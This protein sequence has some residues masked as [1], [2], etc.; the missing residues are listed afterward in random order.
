MN[1]TERNLR[2][3]VVDDDDVSRT[4]LYDHLSAAGHDVLLAADVPSARAVLEREA[5]QIIIADW[6]MPGASGLELCEWVRRHRLGT[7]VHFVM[8]TVLSDKAKLIEA[9]R[10]GVDDFLSKPLHEGELFARLRAWSRIVSLQEELA[11]RHAEVQRSNV[12]LTALNAK[13]ADLAI[14]DELTALPNRREAV[15]RL[16]EQW[17]ISVRYKQPLSCAVLD[18]D[19]FK[20][21]ND[22]L[23]H[24]AGDEVLKE[25]A[26]RLEGCLRDSDG[27]FRLGGDEFLALLPCVGLG[28]AAA[29]ARR[30]EA[31]VA[32]K[33]FDFEGRPLQLSVSV[34]LAERTEG[35][36][37]W[38]DMVEAADQALLARK[39]QRR[40]LRFR[41]AS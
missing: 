36:E 39:R 31:S 7:S 1:L 9:F 29:W 38:K 18:V 2:I 10:A 30:C 33:P 34:G 37:S 40:E 23:G 27:V 20:Q 3:L 12:E 28:E 25:L 4:V 21:V 11:Q 26:G 35:T 15:R 14:R 32:A 17:A 41:S 6:I 19:H 16:Q 13:L 22:S 24:G 8:L 5:V